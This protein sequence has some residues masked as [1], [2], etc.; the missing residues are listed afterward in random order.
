L[1]IFLLNALEPR[2]LSKIYAFDAKKDYPISLKGSTKPILLS[3]L[4]PGKDPFIHY[5]QNYSILLELCRIDGHGA[6]LAVAIEE[7][8]LQSM[9]KIFL[10]LYPTYSVKGILTEGEGW[11]STVDLVL[12][13]S[14]QLLSI[15][16]ILFTLLTKQVNLIIMLTV[17]ILPFFQCCLLLLFLTSVPGKHFQPNAIFQKMP[18][19]ATRF[20]L[21]CKTRVKMLH[22]IIDEDEKDLINIDTWLPLILVK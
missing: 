19:N 7:K 15:M 22:R 13:S 9:F 12:T 21:K 10:R 6:R 16:Q 11:L 5:I 3:F 4:H 8:H 20:G 2:K 14:E 17:L 1:P 18:Y